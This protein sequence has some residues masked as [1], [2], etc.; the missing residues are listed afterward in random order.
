MRQYQEQNH[1][2]E[3]IRHVFR[4][5]TGNLCWNYYFVTVF[6]FKT[7]HQSG[8]DN[9]IQN[10]FL[11]N[12]ACHTSAFQHLHLHHISN[13]P[14]FSSKRRYCRRLYWGVH[15]TV[16]TINNIFSNKYIFWINHIKDDFSPHYSSPNALRYWNPSVL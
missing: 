15:F 8:R 12:S 4:H 13:C 7:R 9:A 14:A 1:R 11:C 6:S 2:E 10:V 3:T 16:T 5:I